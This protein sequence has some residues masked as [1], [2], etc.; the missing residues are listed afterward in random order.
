MPERKEGEGLALAAYGS[1]AVLLLV[2]LLL[3]FPRG[4]DGRFVAAAAAF[5]AGRALWRRAEARFGEVA[6]LALRGAALAAALSLAL[7]PLEPPYSAWGPGAGLFAIGAYL[8]AGS[9]RPGRARHVALAG[10]A[11][12]FA[13]AYRLLA[14]PL[15]EG[16]DAPRWRFDALFAA[17]LASLVLTRLLRASKLAARRRFVA[18]LAR[19]D[20]RNLLVALPFAAYGA[21]RATLAA[22]LTHFAVYEWSLG[23][24]LAFYVAAALRGRFRESL[25]EEP[26]TLEAKRHAGEVEARYDPRFGEAIAT[27]EAFVERG[28]LR[29]RYLAFWRRALADAGVPERE[30]GELVSRAANAPDAPIERGFRIGRRDATAGNAARDKREESHRALLA[31]VVR[32]DSTER[33]DRREAKR[34]GAWSEPRL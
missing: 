2:A 1:L 34:G 13:G 27:F 10:A 21:Y 19:S 32:S 30:A 22:A 29:E 31:R 4:V 14:V 7:L 11:L 5:L 9:S 6:S 16:V 20:L 15:S 24:V 25:A 18:E 12:A 23:L 28:E 8:F 33:N 17:A 26:W 3:G